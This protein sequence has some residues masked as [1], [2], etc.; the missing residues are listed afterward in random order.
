M[1]LL[2]FRMPYRKSDLVLLIR[3]CWVHKTANVLEKLRKGMQPKVKDSL[4][5][6][7]LAETREISY[8]DFDHCIEKYIVKY[9]NVM[10]FFT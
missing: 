2:G 10:N 6:I 5:S 3:V 1:V 4:H 9:D 8:Q 7:Y